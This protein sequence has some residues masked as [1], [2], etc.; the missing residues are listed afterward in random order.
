ML[1]FTLKE[2]SDPSDVRQVAV[3]KEAGKASGEGTA[4]LAVFLEPKHA[5]QHRRLTLGC[6]KR[7]ADVSQ[8]TSSTD[9][10]RG[11]KAVA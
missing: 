10:A 2:P 1:G 4:C 7:L 3:E 5:H 11:A 9:D 6:L 8:G